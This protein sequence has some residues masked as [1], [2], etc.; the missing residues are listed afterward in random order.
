PPPP[1]P[2]P[3]S[4][5]EDLVVF[6]SALLQPGFL[7]AESLAQM[8]TP[9]RPRSGKPSSYGIG[10]GIVSNWRGRTY[11]LHGGDQQGATAH[12]LILPKAKIVIA[13]L[14]NL[15][16]APLLSREDPVLL[17]KCFDVLAPPEPKRP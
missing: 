9:Q 17:V 3:L 13:V 16:K 7:K 8:F 11:Y 15:S 2:P 14:C 1:P 12:L 6:G 4:T 10:W 5:A